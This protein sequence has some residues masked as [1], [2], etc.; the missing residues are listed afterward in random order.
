M[1]SELAPFGWAAFGRAVRFELAREPSRVRTLLRAAGRLLHLG[2]LDLGLAADALLLPERGRGELT[3]GPLFI[4]GHQRT[5]TTALH[6]LLVTDPRLS[7]PRLHELVFPATS[8]QR[9]FA[10]VAAIDEAAGGLLQRTNAAVQ[11][12][13]FGPLDDL[14]RLRLDA[15]E[16]DEIALWAVFA[17]VMC[18][19]GTPALAASATLDDLRHVDRWPRARVDAVFSYYRAV[20]ERHAARVTSRTGRP[21]IVVA[22]NPAFTH[23]VPQLLATFPDARFVFCDRDPVEAIASRLRLVDAIW[24]RRRPGFSGMAAPQVETLVADSVRTFRAAARWARELPR[25]RRIIAR[26]DELERA[27]AAVVGAILGDLLGLGAPSP[28]LAAACGV[29]RPS[30]PR[31]RYDLGAFGLDADALRARLGDVELPDA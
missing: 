30:R 18:A 9:E 20:L 26:L 3:A 14:H 2:V 13:L 6:R 28:E 16:E 31:G 17:S 4:L 21:P 11:Q 27:P 10:R 22:K 1:T 15:V 8:V 5:G 12:R 19:N 23:K 7:A 24:R 25:E 29:A